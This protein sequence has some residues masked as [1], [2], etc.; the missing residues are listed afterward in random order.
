MVLSW[1]PPSFLGNR[2][3]TIYK[4]EC[5]NC[6]KLP[7]F[8]PGQ[9]LNDTKVAITAL[10][11][12]TSYKFKVY[13]ENGAS[14]RQPSQF[15]DITVRMEG[16]SGIYIPIPPDDSLPTNY[17]GNLIVRMSPASPSSLLSPLSSP[18]YPG[19]YYLSCVSL[20]VSLSLSLS[21]HVSLPSSPSPSPLL[22]PLSPLCLLGNCA[23]CF[24]LRQET[25]PLIDTNAS[26]SHE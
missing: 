2:N 25:L 9:E 13:A 24:R 7:T 19:Q 16:E 4:I 22:A 23:H 12:A 17:K 1:S 20:C 8:I 11:I 6:P 10:N 15:S 3:D 21:L 18:S 14:G 26:E 5:E